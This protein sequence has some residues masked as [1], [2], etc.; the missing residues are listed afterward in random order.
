MRTSAR[1][2]ITLH[3]CP[4]LAAAASLVHPEVKPQLSSPG[5]PV[6]A[7]TIF[8]NG[9]CQSLPAAVISNCL[10]PLPRGTETDTGVLAEAIEQRW[11][12]RNKSN[13]FDCVRGPGRVGSVL[14]WVL[15]HARDQCAA[16]YV[17]GRTGGLRERQ[18]AA[19]FNSD[20]APAATQRRAIIMRMG[21][22]RSGRRP[23]GARVRSR[24]ARARARRWTPHHAERRR[25]RRACAFTSRDSI[26][27]A[28]LP[29][30]DRGW[31]GRSHRRRRSACDGRPAM[32]DRRSWI[33][34]CVR[35]RARLWFFTALSPRR[36]AVHLCSVAR[37]VG[38]HYTCWPCW[39]HVYMYAAFVSSSVRSA[40]TV[41]GRRSA[42]LFRQRVDDANRGTMGVVSKQLAVRVAVPFSIHGGSVVRWCILTLYHGMDHGG[43]CCCCI[44]R[45]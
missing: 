41:Q 22:L 25:R 26:C 32:S 20:S 29:G 35:A 23:A 4:L 17:P 38:G 40:G 18:R 42:A 36:A 21:L 19:W 5:N 33:D 13:S 6:R 1:P 43:S 12:R 11:R 3:Q 14:G 16:S 10:R 39:D 2:P 27:G 24:R 44:T 15:A 28:R 37:A 9:P 34:Q 31:V 8:R 30:P 45:S 7:R